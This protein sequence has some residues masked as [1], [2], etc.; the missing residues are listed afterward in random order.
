MFLFNSDKLRGTFKYTQTHGLRPGLTVIHYGFSE[1][2]AISPAPFY[3]DYEKNFKQLAE[4]N[5]DELE[6]QWAIR[7][8][9]GASS[10]LS[11][12]ISGSSLD[13]TNHNRLITVKSSYNNALL[14]T[15]ANLI[16]SAWS[17]MDQG[18][19]AYDPYTE[20]DVLESYFITQSSESSSGHKNNT[21]TPSYFQ[22]QTNDNLFNQNYP[23]S[24][25]YYHIVRSFQ[26]VIYSNGINIF[27]ISGRTPDTVYAYVP[28]IYSPVIG[29]L[30]GIDSYSI[31]VNSILGF[32]S[33]PDNADSEEHPEFLETNTVYGHMKTPWHNVGRIYASYNYLKT[34]DTSGIVTI[35]GYDTF[36]IPASCGNFETIVLYRPLLRIPLSENIYLDSSH[37]GSISMN[38]LEMIEAGH[39]WNQVS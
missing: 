39:N 8:W 2:E 3:Y 14:I 4:H 17:I 13:C 20:D 9:G 15:P 25:P 32:E 10:R 38:Y 30:Y 16:R 22:I 27:P 34:S 31:N 18:E 35:T 12:D 7:S 37:T 33:F 5:Y 23:G 6:L 24:Y 21:F 36:P 1:G 26:F 29:N 11:V 28:K 19:Y